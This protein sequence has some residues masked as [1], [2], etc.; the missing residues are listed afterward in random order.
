[1]VYFIVLLETMN[2][3]ESAQRKHVKKSHG[4][5][6]ISMN[7]LKHKSRRN[8]KLLFRQH[9]K[10]EK[11]DKDT[12]CFTRAV[13]Q[14]VPSLS[15]DNYFGKVFS[16]WLQST[17]GGRKSKIQSDQIVWRAFKFLLACL[18]DLSDDKLDSTVVDSCL[19]S[20]ENVCLFIDTM[21]KVWNIG[22]SGKISYVSALL[23]LMDFSKYEGMSP[24]VIT[25][26]G[27]TEFKLK[28]VK[29][30]WERS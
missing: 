15:K 11:D 1:M 9:L 27:I 16:Q 20:P 30:V 19:G 25:N 26:F 6:I 7:D 2:T 18:E 12:K 8:E 21:G 10:S 22:A 23:D 5:L 24:N 17:I 13:T 28:G 3:K 14:N 29:N 4:W